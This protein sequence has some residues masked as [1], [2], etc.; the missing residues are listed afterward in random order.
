MYKD[1]SVVLIT[2]VLDEEEQVGRMLARVPECVDETVVV[3][4]GSTDRS[5]DVAREAGA[6]VIRLERNSGVGSAG[7]AAFRYAEERGFDVLV[8]IA[9]NG[10]DAP[11]E[12]PRL[13][14][15]VSQGADFVM[16]SRF[17]PGGSCAGD[18][19]LHRRLGTRVHP[20]LVSLFARRRVTESTNGFRAMRRAVLMDERID[21]EQPWLQRYELEVYLL[22]KVLLLRY[23]TAEVP[24]TKR[25]PARGERYTRIVPVLDW[26]RLLRPVFYLGL[27]LRR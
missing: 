8:T 26:W 25:Y 15:A 11:E 12:I 7:R 22:M 3:D 9:G 18:F 27:G 5:A 1:Q 21:L 16:G 20:L 17:L 19:P 6:H 24:C 14:E 2:A 4:D 13:L 10:K 23:Q